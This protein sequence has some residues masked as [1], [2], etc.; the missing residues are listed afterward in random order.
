MAGRR[1]GHDEGSFYQLADGSWKDAITVHLPDG[2]TRRMERR[3]RTKREAQV[4]IAALRERLAAGQPPMVPA[5]TLREYLDYWLMPE[6]RTLPPPSLTGRRR[7]ARDH[8]GLA[9]IRPYGLR[10]TASSIM[11]S[12]CVPLPTINAILGPGSPMVVRGCARMCCRTTT[13]GPS[14][15]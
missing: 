15:G 12:E 5:T 14:R 9:R 8:A 3:G 10:H 4:K 7:A 2:T 1:R 6:W 11:L 13:G